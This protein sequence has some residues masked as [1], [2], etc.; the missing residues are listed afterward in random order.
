MCFIAIHG[1][2]LPSFD[3]PLDQ[4]QVVFG[5]GGRCIN[6]QDGQIWFKLSST[7]AK[8]VERHG[9]DCQQ[10][11]LAFHEQQDLVKKGNDIRIARVAFPDQ[12][13][14]R[15][16]VSDRD[17]PVR[18]SKSSPEPLSAPPLQRA[19][20]ILD[21]SERGASPI[22]SFGVQEHPLIVQNRT[23]YPRGSWAERSSI[24]P[25]DTSASCPLL[26]SLQRNS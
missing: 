9:I 25:A 18:K 21:R 22:S 23:R 11:G 15:D 20:N 3:P 7:P 19:T 10:R 5:L 8:E 1:L 14:Q 12:F 16:A 24:W 6:E 4:S 17:L 26:L 2:D 13:C